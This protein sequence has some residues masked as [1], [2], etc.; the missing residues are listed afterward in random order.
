MRKIT[1]FFLAVAISLLSYAEEPILPLSQVKVG[2]K[3][4]GKTVFQGEKIEEFNVE[5]LGVLRNALGPKMDLILARLS[6]DKVKAAGVMAGMSGSP[7]YIDG[8]LVGAVSLRIG[9][10][11]KE[12]I[13]G[14]TPIEYMLKI[15]EKDKEE[16]KGGF[17]QSDFLGFVK[18]L[19]LPLKPEKKTVLPSFNFL[20]LKG[21]LASGLSF[22]PIE[23]PLVF[24]GF[25]PALIRRYQSVFAKYGFIATQFGGGLSGE[26][27]GSELAPGSA[28]GVQLV[29]GD[30]NL[31]ATG[32]LTYRRGDR[33][34]AFGHPFFLLG[35]TSLPLTKAKVVTILPSLAESSKLAVPTKEVGAVVQDRSAGTLGILGR[36]PLL[37]PIEVKLR[38]KK[39]E[40]VFHYNVALH[41]VFAPFLVQ[42]TLANIIQSVEKGSGDMSIHLSGRIELGDLPSVRIDNLFSGTSA[43]EEASTIVGAIV[44][45]LYNNEFRKVDIRGIRLTIDYSDELREASLIDAWLDKAR[46]KPG[47]PL[48]LSV[49]LKPRRGKPVVRRFHLR[50]PL[51]MSP[52]KVKIVVGDA[53]SVS[54]FEREKLKGGIKPR[55]VEDLIRLLS[56]M[57]RNNIVYAL[58]SRKGESGLLKGKYLPALPPSILAVMGDAGGEGG[59]KKIDAVF[60]DEERLKTEY[61]IIGKRELTLRIT[62]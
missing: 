12:P 51:K 13:V 1:L 15:D 19:P 61:K 41:S 47:E 10:F 16:I 5:I 56:N 30:V 45:Y 42:L 46:A 40:E 43:S 3:G 52:G 48:T 28:I 27:D 22:K 8:K 26:D 2:M 62:E 36:K 34:L 35:A 33:V 37:L 31:T 21:E 18:P 4:V 39:G 60:L 54:A 23:T 11:I 38:S 55:S 9:T 20:P 14:I 53:S 57:R 44:H 50:V 58:F 32:T 6:G 59:F 49:R 25:S 7:V 24:S 29:S 17:L